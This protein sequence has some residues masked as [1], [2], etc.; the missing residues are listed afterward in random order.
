[1]TLSS[2]LSAFLTVFSSMRF[3][4]AFSSH[5]RTLA[6]SH[7]VLN[8]CDSFRKLSNLVETIYTKAI[9]ATNKLVAIEK[10][11]KRFTIYC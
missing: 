10:R 9:V 7:A 5:E 4:L 2:P 8:A 3:N 11:A 1:M 6:F